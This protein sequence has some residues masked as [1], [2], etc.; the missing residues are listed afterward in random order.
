MKNSLRVCVLLGMVCFVFLSLAQAVFAQKVTLSLSPSISEI[1]IKPGESVDIPY[2]VSNLD[3]PVSVS[4]DV[5]PFVPRGTE[6]DISIE[7]EFSGPIRF[8]LENADIDLGNAFSLQTQKGQELRLQIR[9]PDG[10]PEGD[11]YYT[12]FVQTLPGKLT[13]GTT[14]SRAIS[15]IGS[16]ILVTVSSSGQLE[17]K[18]T[19]G[20]L[21]VIPSRKI[22]ILGKTIFFFESTDPIP[23]ILTINNT[24]NNR[25]KPQGT[26]E[27]DQNRGGRMKIEILPQNILAQ[28]SRRLTVVP[29]KGFFVGRRTLRTSITFGAGEI[30]HTAS[31][32]FLA[33][34]FKLITAS[35]IVLGILLAVVITVRK[36]DQK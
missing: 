12:F 33:I 17:T 11:Y 9:V 21:D 10:T 34:P 15:R 20:R 1:V 22:T 29:F 24:G 7:S 16:N 3:D 32:T 36:Q 30:P 25:I 27:L 4:A 5:R 8:S 31:A 26:I 35:L 13:E 14:S 18:G 19:I 6:G 2:K 28:S 23:V